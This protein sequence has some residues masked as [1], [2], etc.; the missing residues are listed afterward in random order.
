MDRGEGEGEGKG[1]EGEK[2]VEGER[3]HIYTCGSPKIT[4]KLTTIMFITTR[5]IYL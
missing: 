4:T 3:T 1:E 5:H 2:E